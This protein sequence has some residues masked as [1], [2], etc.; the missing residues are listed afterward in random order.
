MFCADTFTKIVHMD[1]LKITLDA[2]HF[3]SPRW[4]VLGQKIFKGHKYGLEQLKNITNEIQMEQ[5]LCFFEN[6]AARFPRLTWGEFKD[7]DK[8]IEGLKDLTFGD[9]SKIASLSEI[10]K[11]DIAKIMIPMNG[12][13]RIVDQ[14]IKSA[15]ERKSLKSAIQN[16]CKRRQTFSPTEQLLELVY[17]IYP[18]F[19]VKQFFDACKESHFNDTLTDM[20]KICIEVEQNA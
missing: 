10:E 14:Y 4:L 2:N 17:Q 5:T 9:E 8:N 3:V 13:V 19:T 1:L 15:K 11:L 6:F 18:K 20:K 7:I 16:S 12:W